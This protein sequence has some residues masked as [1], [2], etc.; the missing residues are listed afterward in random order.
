M[1]R[2]QGPWSPI[3]L[4]LPLQPNIIQCYY[5]RTEVTIVTAKITKILMIYSNRL[6]I[7][8]IPDQHQRILS[9]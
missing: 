7:I 4:N 1:A 2:R 8:I 9:F 3:L 5:D 6:Y